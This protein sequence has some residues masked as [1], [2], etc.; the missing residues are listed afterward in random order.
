MLSRDPLA[1]AA[2]LVVACSCSFALATPIAML[3]SVGCG[4]KRGLLIKGGRYLEL[5]ARA[6]VLLVD[7]T[8]TVTLGRPQITDIVQM[9]DSQTA[10]GENWAGKHTVGSYPGM[11]TAMSCCV[12]GALFGAPAGRGGARGRRDAGWFW[13]SRAI[14]SPSQGWACAR[15]W[16][17]CPWPW[18]AGGSYR[19]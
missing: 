12:C 11:L 13:R 15:R 8:G 5:L 1:T 4:A 17:A 18:A 16:M 7:K 2:V 9:A 19:T 3:A 14:L 10:D 6:D